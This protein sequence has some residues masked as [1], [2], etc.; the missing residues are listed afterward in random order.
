M[1]DVSAKNIIQVFEDAPT[2][3][4]E[5]GRLWYP[6]ARKWCRVRADM[7]DRSVRTVAGVVSALSPR[8]RWER[9]LIDADQVLYAYHNGLSMPWLKCATFSQNVHKA[10]DILWK[11]DPSLAET[12]PKTRAFLDCIENE[13]TSAVVVDVWAYR[14]AHGNPDLKAKG[15]TEKQYQ[16]YEECYREAASELSEP[17]HEVQA[18]TWVTFR[19]RSALGMSEGQL[20]LL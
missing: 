6:R 5:Q 13:D 17:V 14:V 15:F 7:Y 10:W 2:D 12:S 19:N 8:N 11:D 16:V 9:N 3:L 20:R 18:V 1:E 4:K